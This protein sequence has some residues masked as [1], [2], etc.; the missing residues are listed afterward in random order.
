MYIYFSLYKAYINYRRGIIYSIIGYTNTT[1]NFQ[2]LV[3]NV[4]YLFIVY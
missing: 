1:I 2:F 3:N 4:I